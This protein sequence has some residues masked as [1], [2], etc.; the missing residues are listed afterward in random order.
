MCGSAH[1]CFHKIAM[2]PSSM[3]AI[4]HQS[5]ASIRMFAS[6]RFLSFVAF[7]TDSGKQHSIHATIQLSHS[8][9]IPNPRF[10]AVTQPHERRDMALTRTLLLAEVPDVKAVG[11]LAQTRC[12]C[13][14]LWAFAVVLERCCVLVLLYLTGGACERAVAK[15]GLVS[16]CICKDQ[17]GFE[18]MPAL[19]MCGCACNAVPARRRIGA[20]QESSRSWHV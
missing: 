20:H 4:I 3:Y 12:E 17:T 2:C 6:R 19:Q 13:L 18:S 15:R 11:Q 10:H 16:N 8:T 9:L 5:G 1:I 7:H 14:E